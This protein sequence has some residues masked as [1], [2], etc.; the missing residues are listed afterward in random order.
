MLLNTISAIA[1]FALTIIAGVLTNMIS[2]D[3]EKRAHGWASS[4]IMFAVKRLPPK[5]RAR[6]EEEWMADLADQPS[7]LSQVVFA[8]GLLVA[9]RN[10][11]V[12]DRRQTAPYSFG[13]LDRVKKRLFD[14]AITTPILV[15]LAPLMV[16]VAIAIKFET[17]GPVFFR[18][19]RLGRGA[20]R[21]KVL[22]FR[23][24]YSEV[25]GDTRTTRIGRFIRA[26]SLDELPQLLNVLAGDMSLVGPRPFRLRLKEGVPFN[27]LIDE[28]KL[29]HNPVKPGI[30]G[31]A[32]ISNVRGA[33]IAEQGQTDPSELII[34]YTRG[35]GIWR[36][37]KMLATSFVPVRGTTT[38]V[39]DVQEDAPDER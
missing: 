26:Q 6:F 35:W 37:I 2:T 27:R 18:Q 7:P 22:K 34:E 17:R 29:K 24:M 38:F 8:V 14:L 15:I 23:S 10:I 9:A 31:L 20:R 4:L 1:L 39:H 19:D 13:M 5:F 28:A 3:V 33:K 36:E 11:S 25:G 12:A 32:L 16:V 21:F 30:T